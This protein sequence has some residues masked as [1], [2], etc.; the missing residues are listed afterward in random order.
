MNGK[1]PEDQ[2]Y[3]KAVPSRELIPMRNQKSLLIQ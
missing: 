3:G 1:K 2:I